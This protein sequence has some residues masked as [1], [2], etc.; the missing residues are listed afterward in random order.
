[1]LH[2]LP[3]RAVPE[4]SLRPKTPFESRNCR[5]IPLECGACNLLLAYIDSETRTWARIKFRDLYILIEDA[6]QLRITCR[7][8]GATNSFFR[9]GAQPSTS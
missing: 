7:Q 5:D 4:P 1:M 3:T 6:K 8:C 9:E 2:G